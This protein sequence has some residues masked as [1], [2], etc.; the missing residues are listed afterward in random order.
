MLYLT[1]FLEN[2]KYAQVIQPCTPTMPSTHYALLHQSR[3]RQTTV[4]QVCLGTPPWQLEQKQVS[5]PNLSVGVYVSVH[6]SVP[7][8]TTVTCISILESVGNG[9]SF[10]REQ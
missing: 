5:M 3:V 6:R 7:Y 10:R 8:T 4:Q 1:Q 2:Y 9:E